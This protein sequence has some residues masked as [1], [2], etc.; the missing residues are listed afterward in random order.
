[1]DNVMTLHYII[2]NYIINKETSKKRRKMYGF[3]VDL[4][5]AFDKVDRKISWKT[6]EERDIRTGLNERVKEIYVQIKNAVSTREHNKLILDEKRSKARMSPEPIILCPCNRGIA[7]VEEEMKKGQVDGVLIEKD[8]TLAY[9]ED[10]IV[11]REEHERN[12]EKAGKIPKRQ[13][14]AAECREVVNVVFLWEGRGR[15]RVEWMWKEK[16]IEEMPEFKYL[17]YVLKKNGGDDGQVRELKTKGNIV[18]K[19]IWDL[20]ERIFKDDF[21]RRI[22]L[23]RYS[24]MGIIIYEKFGNGGKGRSWKYYKRSI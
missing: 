13:K 14:L 15:R 12:N 3:F 1:M 20:G 7:D 10:M 17:D 18:I 11:S 16:R 19:K 23:F 4:K 5:A 24:V 8:K 2:I 21:R 9:A 22:I 6:M